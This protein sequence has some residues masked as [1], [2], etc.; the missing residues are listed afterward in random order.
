MEL[1]SRLSDVISQGNQWCG[2]QMLAVFTGYKKITFEV[3][4]QRRG[5]TLHGGLNLSSTTLQGSEVTKG[6]IRLD[7]LY[8][9]VEANSNTQSREKV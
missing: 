6:V 3:R 7:L 4:A 9:P 5:F 1:R 2:R 8:L